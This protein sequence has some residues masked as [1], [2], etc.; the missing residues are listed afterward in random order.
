MEKTTYPRKAVP[1][2]RRIAARE[3]KLA[4]VTGSPY[5]DCENRI[6][7]SPHTIPKP[8]PVRELDRIARVRRGRPG[9]FMKFR[10]R[11]GGSRAV[12]N[13][14]GRYGL[15]ACPFAGLSYGH[16]RSGLPAVNRS[17]R[18]VRPHSISPR[19]IDVDRVPLRSPR[20]PTRGTPGHNTSRAS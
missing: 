9:K 7:R 13:G 5:A 16:R 11:C 3:L 15:Q 10:G 1:A 4:H 12:G 19:H 18:R 17:T 20:I 14:L 8:I 2:I 6:S